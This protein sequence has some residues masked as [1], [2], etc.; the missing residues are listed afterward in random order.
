MCELGRVDILVDVSKLSRHL[1]Q[2]FHIFAYLKHHLKSR[3]VF[4]DH[5]MIHDMTNFMQCDWSE[6]YLG[7]AE[8]GPPNA[9]EL[10]RQVRD[11]DVLRRR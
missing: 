10:P 6:F 2:V 5:E 4:D 9:P 1:E 11:D 8:T 7:A 3:M